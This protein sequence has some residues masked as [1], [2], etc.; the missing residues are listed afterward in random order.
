MKRFLLSLILFAS[1]LP[2][3]EIEFDLLPGG[4]ISGTAG[5]AVGWGYTATNNSPDEW[6]VFVDFNSGTFTS[7]TANAL[8]DYPILAPETTVTQPYNSVSGTGLMDVTLNSVLPNPIVDTG[9]FVLDAQWWSGDPFSGGDYLSDA[10]PVILPYELDASP[11]AVTEP[12]T[13]WLV[14]VVLLS[15]G[16]LSK[17]RAVSDRRR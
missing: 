12:S 14:G 13:L 5:S 8:F 11:V 10:D 9:D 16:F 6:L 7:G 1:R 2:G 4:T 17:R 15:V 3:A